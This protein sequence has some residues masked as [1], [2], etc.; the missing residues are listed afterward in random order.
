MALAL[1]WQQRRRRPWLGVAVAVAWCEVAGGLSTAA[2]KAKPSGKLLRAAKFWQRA[3]PIVGKYGRDVLS[4]RLK[5]QFL[6]ECLSDEECEV[7]WDDAHRSGAA[8]ARAVVDELGGFYVK[9]G[10]IIASRS[11]LFPRQYGEA[12]AGLTDLVD[13]MDSEF[14]RSIVAEEVL[15]PG[16]RWDDVFAEWD[17]DPLGA[18]S[19]AQVHR[20]TLTAT[21]GSR[22]VAVK[23]QR[24]KVEETLL[25]D[26]SEL[27]KLAKPLRDV[28]PVDYYVV[29]S[30]LETQLKDE[31]DFV[32]EAAAMDRIYETLKGTGAGPPPLVVPRVVAPLSTKRVLVMDYL[33]GEPLSRVAARVDFDKDPVLRRAGEALL[34]ALTEAFGACIFKSGFFHADPHP[35]NLLLLDD[36][37]VGLIDFGQVKQISG[38]NRATLGKVMLALATRTKSEAYPSGTPDELL[39]C[40]TLG[41]ELGVVLNP[42]APP[43]GPAA[44]SMWLFDDASETLP[45]GYEQNELSPNSPATALTSFPQDLV[46]VARSSV[47]IKGLAAK[48]GVNWSLASKW[49]PIAAEALDLHDGAGNAPALSPRSGRWGLRK[50]A[51]ARLKALVAP[52]VA[53]RIKAASR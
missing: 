30:E 46:L 51:K 3:V 2:P 14:V 15:R 45:G 43:E 27:K 32:A 19:V 52:L 4:M 12:L 36:G 40:A 13:P 7:I 20:A 34:E 17:D 23:V 42:D 10:Q 35:G 18:A 21:Y 9:T 41:T 22:E 44:V 48:L 6:G 38:K 50:A 28:T 25:G 39:K 37:R 49:A 33:R 11:D 31:F 24:P 47:L 1:R 8:Q 16:E 53:R 5:E 29:F 26:V